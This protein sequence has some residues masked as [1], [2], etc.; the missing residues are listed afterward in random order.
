[1]A[2]KLPPTRDEIVAAWKKAD[3]ESAEPVGAAGVARALGISQH[4]IRKL[5]PEDSL[6]DLKR[7]HGIRL[8]PQEMHATREELCER[9]DQ[10]VTEHQQIPSWNLLIHKTGI[11]EKTWKKTVGGNEGCAKEA[12][13]AS[14][15]DWLRTTR[16][17]SANIAIYERFVSRAA[18]PRLTG[19][20]A[21]PTANGWIATTYQK[22]G[23]RFVGRRLDFGNL[24]FEPTNEQGVVFLFGM[25]SQAL[26]FES[27]EYLGYDFPDCEAKRLVGRGQLEHVRIE[28]EYQSRN[29]SHDR[30]ACDVI[31]CWENNWGDECPLEVI[32]LKTAIKL[33]RDRP[34]FQAHRR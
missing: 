25:V 30:N 4:W 22:L 21:R 5:F 12:V 13:L 33:L 31:V 24:A 28:F 2:K 6:T 34:E 16:P 1:M 26:G 23:R 19:Q 17:D 20:V 29:Y 11:S 9:F 7:Q 3:A 14:Y 8:S 32:E 10:I 15:F 27:I 18:D